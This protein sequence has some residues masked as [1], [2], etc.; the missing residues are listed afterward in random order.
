MISERGKGGSAVR[1]FWSAAGLALVVLCAGSTAHGQKS[2]EQYIP[3]GMSPGVSQKYASL[4]VIDTVSA[5]LRTATIA[6]P[7]ARRTVRITDKT[8]I[9]LDRSKLKLP[10]L[11]GRFEDLQ[12]GRRVE[13]K[14]LDAERQV[15]DWVK[16]EMTAP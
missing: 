2:T 7:A 6:E 5:R 13:V 15:A 16:V 1:S 3:I 10:N 11:R 12:K 8:H 9:W 4:G 14:Y